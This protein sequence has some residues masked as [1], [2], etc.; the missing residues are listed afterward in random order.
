MRINHNIAALNT[1]RQLAGN[2]TEAGKSLEKLSSGLR[3]NRAGDDAAGLAISEKMRS[4]IRGL[5]QAQRNSQDA[6]SLIQTAEGAL[7]ET[8][9]ILQRMRE[10][11]AQS[12]NGTN[13]IEDRQAIQEE[14]NQL[15]SEINRIG[16]TTEFNTKSLMKGELN[17][18]KVSTANVTGGAVSGNISIT[19]SNTAATTTGSALGN[20]SISAVGGGTVTGNVAYGTPSAANSGPNVTVTSATAAGG[21]DVAATLGAGFSVVSA[22][23]QGATITSSITYANSADPDSGPNVTAGNNELTI[24]LNGAIET[25]ELDVL[26]YG[27]GG[28]DSA[29]DFVSDLETKIQALGGAFANVTVSIDAND[30]ILFK[31]NDADDSFAITGGNALVHLSTAGN[32]SDLATAADTPN[33]ELTLTVGG[34]T[35]TISLSAADY[36]MTGAVGRNAFLADLNT[37]LGGAFGAGNVVATFNGDNELVLTNNAAGISS[38][39]TSISGSAATALGLDA[40]NADYVQG[41]EKNLL[42]ITLN[43]ETHTVSLATTD[44]SAGGNDGAVQFVADIQA[45]IQALGG[46][47]A[48]VTVGFDDNNNIMFTTADSSDEFTIDGGGAAALIG[49]SFTTGTEGSG[50]NQLSV[51]VGG[52][53]KN[54]TLADGSYDFTVVG[55]RTTFLTDL[56]SKLDTAFGTGNAVASFN[57]DNELVITNSLTGSASTIG[58]V[59]GSAASALGLGSAALQQGQ[60]ANNTGTLTI[61]GIDV[62]ISLTAGNYTAGGLASDLQSQIRAA[63]PALA[64]AT[65]SLADGKFV[66]SSGTQGSD[67]SVT[68]GADELAKTLKL[69]ASEGAQSTVGADAVDQG[70]KMQIGANNGQTLTVDIGDMR[71]L[72][73]GISGT[74]AGAAQGSVAGAAFTSTQSVTNGTNNTGA[75]YG[76]DVTTSEKATAAIEVLDNAIKTISNE[77]SKL[78]AFQNRLEHT[79]NNLGASAENLTAAESRIRDVDMAKEM[80]EFTKNN[81]LSQAAQAMLAQANQQPQGVLQLLR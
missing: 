26:N 29:A 75:E 41:T 36:D 37:Q 18:Q 55:D 38:T 21:V 27:A 30:N 22:A 2:T 79:I 69:T 35:Q 11:A 7:N 31:T 59:T 46:D 14:I 56:N 39:I 12:A 20:V 16:N 3:I 28:D 43:N 50:N 66:I 19:N 8:H 17:V 10:L 74:G 23:T 53:K 60:N 72:A 40:A 1:H 76:L 25:I 44:Y 80:M 70:L 51:T 15:T 47:F 32:G 34:N 61:D 73:L 13:S 68:I 52:A 64:N 57:A 77:R 42:T 54:I 78:G 58:A 65:V 24:N 48:S 4:Q 45:K 33:N 63:D 5:N 6:I 62:N 49:T 67:G 81:I 71:S 9:S